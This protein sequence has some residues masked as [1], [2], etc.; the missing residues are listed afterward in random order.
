[1]NK[2]KDRYLNIDYGSIRYR[3][4]G[5]G[6]LLL[7]IHGIAGF[8]EE[9]SPAMEIL[10]KEFKVIALDLPGHGLSDKPDVAYTLDFLADSLKSFISALDAEKV[11]LAGHSLGGAVCLNFAMRY[12]HLT[13]RLFLINSVF[14]KTPLTIR[15]GSFGFLPNLLRKIPYFIVKMS[16][17]LTFYDHRLISDEWLKDAYRYMNEPGS[18]R[19]MFSIIRSIVSLSGL[20]KSVLN[21]FLPGISQITVPT[22]IIYGEKDRIIPIENSRLLQ[23]YIPDSSCISFSNCGH[24]LQY[25]RCDQFC[26]AVAGFAGRQSVNAEKVP[27]CER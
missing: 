9:W 26:Q 16:A 20:R 27:S 4:A 7:L 10:S 24:E 1:M 19:A 25:E 21:A 12:P 6:P 13:E 17:R 5:N 23:Q 14:T 8:L 18:L 22:L 11:C 3:E 2:P 15:L